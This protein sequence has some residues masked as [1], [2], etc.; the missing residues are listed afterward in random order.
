MSRLLS[1]PTLF[2]PVVSDLSFER[3][4]VSIATYTNIDKE[5]DRD[6]PRAFDK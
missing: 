4:A 5:Y 1:S 3:F 2:M 6:K